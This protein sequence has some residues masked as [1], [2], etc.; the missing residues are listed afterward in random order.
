MASAATRGDLAALRMQLS[1]GIR[2]A[3]MVIVPASALYIGLA[4]PIIVA[5]L[6]RGA[7][8][9][10]DASAVSDTLVAFS[11]GLLPFSIYLFAM[12]A[13]YA[14][15]DTYTPFWIN[16]IENVVNIALAFPLYAWLG[17]PGLA[18]AFALAYFVGAIV[19]LGVL[20]VRLDGIDGARIMSSLTRIVAAGVVVGGVSWAVGEFVGWS[21]FGHA[22][23]AVVAGTAIGGVVY[24]GLLM[25]LRVEELS[26]VRSLVPA[27]L[28]SRS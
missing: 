1:R 3:A 27:R 11:V 15:H 26:E 7:F 2:L 10:A 13:F 6:Q 12:R 4:R 21:S 28:R 19:T 16:C 25:L 17:I 23:V 18:L 9:A 5:L 14:R 22:V 20:R 8:S 24:L